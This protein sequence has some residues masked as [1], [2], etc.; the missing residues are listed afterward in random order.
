MLDGDIG[1]GTIRFRDLVVEETQL[2]QPRASMLRKRVRCVHLG[3]LSPSSP[4]IA[5]NTQ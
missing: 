2:A 5:G 1:K 4:S 3:D